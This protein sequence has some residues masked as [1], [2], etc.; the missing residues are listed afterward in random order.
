MN[1]IKELR[2]K[3]AKAWEEAKTFLDERQSQ[4]ENG[5]LSAEDNEMYELMEQEVVDLGKEIDRLE[6]QQQMDRELA[7]ATTEPLTSRPG[8]D[9]QQK[10]G[11]ASEAYRASFW[12]AM[13]NKYGSAVHNDALSVGEDAEGGYLVPS[14]YEATLIQALEETNLLRSLCHVMQTSHGERKI[15][16]VASHGSA[17]WMDEAEVFTESGETF[18]QVSLAAYKLGTML[19]VSDELLHD[20]VFN[21]ESYIAGEFARRIG[22]AEEEAFVTGDGSNKPTGILHDSLGAELGVTAASTGAIAFDEVF[23]LYHSLRAPY[24]KQASF[25]VNDS[26]VKAIRKLK[27]GQGQ[28]IWQASVT[29]GQP[30]TLLNRPLYTSQF[31]P[32]IGANEKTVAFGDFS[33]YWIADRSGRTFKRL[34]ELYAANGQIGFMAYQRL[35]A[36]LI[37]PE[38]VKVLQQK[39]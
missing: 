4:T 35:D 19:K 14:E 28:Y 23:D 12:G 27:D 20:S 18:T 26:T 32:T 5:I 37:L 36:K 10:T 39:A 6:R 34:N 1:R 38:A 29:A 9:V 15:P 24:R 11:R 2:E 22:A 31:M 30:D 33:Y 13:R 7:T 25:L 21:L 3:R 8:K 16:V 17:N